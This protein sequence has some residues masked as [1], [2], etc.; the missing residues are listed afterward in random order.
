MS[1]HRALVGARD[2]QAFLEHL[3]AELVSNGSNEHGWLCW[4]KQDDPR[5]TR[6]GKWIRKF[7]I[8]EAPQV[9]N[10]LAGQMSV[11]GP[12]P[13]IQELNGRS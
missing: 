11:V 10:V 5:I 6:V 13:H 9:F 3:Q 1:L 2:P 4:K 12:R 7:S 8:D